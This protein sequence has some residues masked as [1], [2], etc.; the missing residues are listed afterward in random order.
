[1]RVF[2]ISDLHLALA[3]DKPMDV[4]GASW[5]NYMYRIQKSWKEKV[6]EDDLVL[7]PGDISWVTYH[8]RAGADFSFIEALPGKKIIS[9]GNHDYWWTTRKKLNEF[10]KDEGFESIN[11]LHNNAYFFNGLAIAGTRGW[12]NPE[13]EGFTPE[14]EKIYNRELERLKL[15][16]KQTNGFQGDIIAMLHYPP[17]SSNRN[18]TAFTDILESFGVDICIYGHLHG[19]SCNNAAEG[20]FRGVK[21]KLV[22]ADYLE[23]VPFLLGEW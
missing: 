7:L 23:F 2:A 19:I 1:M 5:A 20:E 22:S 10:I 15:S 13:D 14:D 4:F 6:R 9:K 12:K 21:Y 11:F 3:E 18:S 17:F 8:D 16:L